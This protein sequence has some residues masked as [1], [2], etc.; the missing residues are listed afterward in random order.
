MAITKKPSLDLAKATLPG[1]LL[2]AI[3]AMFQSNPDGSCLVGG[4]ALAGFYAG[5]RRSD[6]IDLFTKDE[7]AQ[8]ATVSAARALVDIGAKISG[9][10]ESR[11]H[12]HCLAELEGHRFTVDVVLDSHFHT[13]PKMQ[14]RVGNLHVANL[15]GLL[16]MKLATLVSRCSEKD[17]Y[18]LIWL[19]EKYR[20]PHFSEFVS[21]G[22]TIDTSVSEESILISLSG[23][24]LRESACHF[25]E[26]VGVSAGSVFKRV[27]AFKMNLIR[28][29]SLYL[30]KKDETFT[31]KSV[32]D[33]MKG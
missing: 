1:P 4:T 21:L 19:F 10:R 33:K 25:A 7:F 28:E 5:H 30:K 22:Q 32:L 12:F 13:L 26:Q 20:K 23:T 17:L 29:Y 14:T 16:A 11:Q 2:K 15:D 27:N 9:Q 31:L 6:D 3:E 8:R 18:D 24:Q